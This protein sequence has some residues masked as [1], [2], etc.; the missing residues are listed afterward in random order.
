MRPRRCCKGWWTLLP[1]KAGWQALPDSAQRRAIRLVNGA[2]EADE[3]TFAAAKRLDPKNE[4][5]KQVPTAQPQ[6]S[7]DCSQRI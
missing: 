1:I 6:L 7:T 5:L 2:G 4:R 3:D